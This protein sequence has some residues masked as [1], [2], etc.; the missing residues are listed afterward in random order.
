MLYHALLMHPIIL[1]SSVSACM[2]FRA[3]A[4]QLYRTPHAHFGLRKAVVHRLRKRPELYSEYVPDD[5]PT[6]CRQMEKDGTW[7]DH[8]TLQVRPT[9]V[10]ICVQSVL[11]LL[12]AADGAC[13]RAS[14]GCHTH[15]SGT[16]QDLMQHCRCQSQTV[17]QTHGMCG[18]LQAVSD[19]FG[20]KVYVLTS[21]PGSEFIEISPS[22]G[23]VR[24]Q[25][26]LYVSFWAEVRV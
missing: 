26:I 21:F 24:S 25:R 10:H 20:V 16:G 19:L 13:C 15:Q 2:Q 8:V 11:G 5:F 9:A 22:D 1:I 12:L 18:S 17:G 6:Y 14:M 3:V 23:K 7:G 4:D